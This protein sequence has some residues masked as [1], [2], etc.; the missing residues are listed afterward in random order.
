MD[1]PALA[2]L[3]VPRRRRARR[4]A[5]AALA[6]A[7]LVAGACG[8]GD[9][10]E[11]SPSVQAGGTAGSADPGDQGDQS[12]PAGEDGISG[13]AD[14]DTPA[15][16]S[17]GSESG[18]EASQ[19]GEELLVAPVGT[20]APP[21]PE[22]V[23]PQFGGTLRVA[24]EAEADGLNPA[25]NNFATS[26]YVM[27]ASIFDNY[28]Y[29]DAEGNWIPYLAESFTDLGDGT[30]W[31]MK[32]REGVRFHDGTYL[33]ADDVIA[34][35][36]AQ[37]AD[38]VIALAFRN[39]VDPAEFVRKIDDLTLELRVSRPRSRLP[40]IFAGQLGMVLPSEWLERAATDTTMNQMPVGTGPFMIESRVQDEKTVLVRNP[41]YWAAD[42]VE[43]YLD[44]IEIEPITDMAIAAERLAAGELDVVI[45]TNAEATLIMREAS[46]V[47]T[48]E[49]VR[50]DEGFAAIN[51]ERPP[52]DDIR[53]RQALTFASDRDAYVALI[54]QGTSP[55]ADT[56]FHPD[57][58]WHNPAVKQETNQPERA[59]PLVEAYCADYPENCSGGR[60]DMEIVFGGPSVENTRITE[61]QTYA[62]EDYFNVTP[63]EVLQDKLITDVVLGEYNVVN[64]RQFGGVDPDGD[65][66]W[67]ECDSVGFISL[68]FTRYC[69][70][71]R[72][73]LMFESRGIHDLQRRVEI[74]HRIQEMVRDSYTYIFYYHTN[75]VIG[76]RDNVHGIC[77]Q[78][79][80]DGI[81]LWCSGSARM[82]LRG[83][84]LS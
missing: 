44:R 56:M 84:W 37:L 30:L 35:V 81:K 69:D 83:A 32:L 70:P 6:A 66:L 42:R 2:E 53:A 7:A 77:T 11:G 75:W 14:T 34:T 55:A 45:T 58:V 50:A 78:A 41:D 20:E 43:I 28:A 62:W 10:G 33:D 31:E 19:E 17:T 54:R 27:A 9:D 74:W 76:A 60:I 51:S 52:F 36:G 65:A 48:I 21:P 26:S 79:S 39:A 71:E 63:V 40:G 5:A 47:K 22:D 15:D 23:E 61:L 73:E 67:L 24:V 38:P 12:S 16:S 18:P 72:D 3:G 29:Y 25:A 49:N 8:G 1:E 46:G 64:W 4:L 68:N 13:D 57:L 80:P 59:G 82:Q